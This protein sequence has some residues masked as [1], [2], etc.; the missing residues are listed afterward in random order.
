MAIINPIDGLHSFEQRKKVGLPYGYGGAYY[1]QSKYGYHD[2]RAGIYRVISW[3]SRQK[4]QKMKF[5][6]PFN[7]QTI[8]QQSWRT[9][10]ANAVAGWQALT[11]EQK[12][13]YNESAKYKNM[14]GYN[15]YI[16][17]QLNS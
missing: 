17:E 12:A 2:L 3:F 7:P 14:S 9:E 4:I 15:W 11:P 1:G 13:V 16:R 5:Y 8:P 10:F 6:R